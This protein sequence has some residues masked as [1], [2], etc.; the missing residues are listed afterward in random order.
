M[1]LATERL[2]TLRR[3]YDERGQAGEGRDF[4][5]TAYAALLLAAIVA[6]PLIRA[7]VVLLAQPEVIAGLQARHAGA[8]VAALCAMVL[9]GLAYLGRLRGPVTPQPFVVT[10][11]ATTDLP[12]SLTLRRAFLTSALVITAGTSSIGALFSGVLVAAGTSSLLSAVMFLLACACFGLIGSVVWLAGQQARLWQLSTAV[13][14]LLVGA[15]LVWLLPFTAAAFPWGWIGLLWPTGH[16][17]APWPLAGLAVA[18]VVTM[19]CAPRL[20]NSLDASRLLANAQRWQAASTAAISGDVAHAIGMFRARPTVGR[21]WNAVA[22][23]SVPLR[24]LR[25]DLVA[26]GRTPGRLSV[27]VP[28]LIAAWATIAFSLTVEASIVWLPAAAG[29]T[30]GYLALGVFSDGLRHAAQATSAPPLYGYSTTGLYLLHALWPAAIAS[31]MAI[32]GTMLAV[33]NG[34]PVAS[35]ITAALL[36]P[37]FLILRAYDSAKGDLPLML[38]TPTPTPAGDMSGL[39]VLAWQADT[40]LIAATTGAAI[41][42]LV[43]AGQIANALLVALTVVAV[44]S[45]MLRRRLHN[46]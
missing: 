29:S 38:L 1:S 27:G 46:L 21:T 3:V 6:F 14:T 43:S 9:V 23:R 19:W 13:I 16:D 15:A 35:A 4:A 7:I 36:I 12:R 32:A 20:L 34:V 31:T 28:C 44:L 25:R 30:I 33:V 11:L 37:L 17:L 5:Y 22:A 2:R 45:Y 10:L 40:L 39:F 24:F 18:T 41:T 42:A 26:T 8:V